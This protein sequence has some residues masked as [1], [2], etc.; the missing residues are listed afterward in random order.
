MVWPQNGEP[1]G[2]QRLPG[3]GPQDRS[4]PQKEQLEPADR[5]EYQTWGP[6]GKQ[7]HCRGLYHLAAEGPVPWGQIERW[8]GRWQLPGL[9]PGGQLEGAGVQQ[10]ALALQE[11]SGE[12]LWRLQGLLPVGVLGAEQLGLPRG[13][14]EVQGEG[15][16][17]Q[18]QWG[19][20]EQR[21]SQEA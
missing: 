11:G 21:L 7:Q 2:C 3:Q 19:W 13:S 5:Q 18:L 16:R 1:Q 14:W 12:E 15:L 17:L 6:A 9:G 20:E 4:R 8:V 10:G